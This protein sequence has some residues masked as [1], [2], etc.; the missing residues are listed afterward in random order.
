VEPIIIPLGFNGPRLSGNGGYVSGVLARGLGACAEVSLRRPTPL[1][2]PLELAAAGEGVV[3]RQGDALIAE[4]RPAEL[5]VADVPRVSF[6]EAEAAAAQPFSERIRRLFAHC[7]VCGCD[8]PQGDGLRLFPGP[9]SRDRP[10]GS[11]IC[12]APWTPTVNL[13]GPDGRVDPAYVWAALD[14]PAGIALSAVQ[15]APPDDPSVFLL[16]RQAVRIDARPRPGERCVVVTWPTGQEGRKHYAEGA[17]LDEGG[18]TLAVTRSTWI[19][20]E[21]RTVFG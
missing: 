4:A 6:A 1:D 5:T 9:V 16:G 14:C 8:R 20:V 3:L 12:A 2:A 13:S 10:R 11:W 19:E 18:E 15:L 7:F 17:L 21:R